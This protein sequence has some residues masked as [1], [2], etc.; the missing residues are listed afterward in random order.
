VPTNH[1]SYVILEDWMQ[2]NPKKFAHR[3]IVG[4]RNVFLKIEGLHLPQYSLG[5]SHAGF[6]SSDAA[7]HGL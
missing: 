6:T 7:G 4:A 2:A 5:G 1:G 3:W